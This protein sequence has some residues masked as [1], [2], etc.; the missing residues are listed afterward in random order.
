MRLRQIA[1]AATDLTASVDALTDVLG[2]EVAFNDPG[3]AAFG[4]VNAVMPSQSVPS[5]TSCV[6]VRAARAS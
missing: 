5:F 6:P 2:I 3:V 4:L 1:L